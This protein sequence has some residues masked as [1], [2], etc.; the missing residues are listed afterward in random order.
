MRVPGSWALALLGVVVLADPALA[1]CV[2][3][4]ATLTASREGQAI[5][6]QLNDAILLMLCAPYVVFGSVAAVVLRSRIR[7]SLVRAFSRFTR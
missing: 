6:R 4:K 3:C 5:S 1:Q 2:M 7:R